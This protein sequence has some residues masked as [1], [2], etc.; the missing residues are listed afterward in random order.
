[1][2]AKIKFSINRFSRWFAV[3]CLERNVTGPEKLSKPLRISPLTS[4][5]LFSEGL[6]GPNIRGLIGEVTVETRPV[7]LS[8]WSP[9]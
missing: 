6:R 9:Q 3:S 2:S 7:S 5:D 4:C 8:L 1:M